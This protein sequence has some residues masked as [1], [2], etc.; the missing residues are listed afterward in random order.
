MDT[1]ALFGRADAKG[2]PLER[3]HAVFSFLKGRQ[4]LSRLRASPFVSL[5]YHEAEFLKRNP[6]RLRLDQPD[7]GLT[8]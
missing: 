6:R 3:T 1:T 4:Y 2:W 8:G 5:N 7:S